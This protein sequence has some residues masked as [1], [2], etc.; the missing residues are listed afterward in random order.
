MSR[1]PLRS[2]RELPSL[3]EQFLFFVN[4]FISL[5][6]PPL[7]HLFYY[8]FINNE[9]GFCR[10]PNR[11]VAIHLADFGNLRRHKTTALTAGIKGKEAPPPEP[12]SCYG[13]GSS[14]F[15]DLIYNRRL[16]HTDYDQL[17]NAAQQH[18]RGRVMMWDD[19]VCDGVCVRP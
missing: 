5:S 13:F 6:P 16:F 14:S 4:T 7:K 17:L 12:D 18:G 15:L 3:Y 11:T 2:R 9:G 10:E 8:V 1:S 19:G